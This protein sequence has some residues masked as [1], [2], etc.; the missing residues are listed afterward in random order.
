M[1]IILRSPVSNYITSVLN[2]QTGTIIPIVTAS[3]TILNSINIP[4]LYPYGS[5]LIK[6]E[7]FDKQT[8]QKV[9]YL[10]GNTEVYS[11]NGTSFFIQ[12]SISKPGNYI[13]NA[14]VPNDFT[15]EKGYLNVTVNYDYSRLFINRIFGSLRIL[16]NV[17]N[18]YVFDIV[19]TYGNHIN[20]SIQ[21][22]L[23]DLYVG[24]NFIPWINNLKGYESQ[25]SIVLSPD[26]NGI[27][28]FVF[29]VEKYGTYFIYITTNSNLGNTSI[30]NIFNYFFYINVLVSD[31]AS[32]CQEDRF[33]LEFSYGLIESIYLSKKI[34]VNNHLFKGL[35]FEK[36]FHFET[37]LTS[38]Q[39]LNYKINKPQ[40]LTSI[41]HR[42]DNSKG[43]VDPTIPWFNPKLR[44][45]SVYNKN[46]NKGNKVVTEFLLNNPKA[47]GLNSAS[48]TNMIIN[49]AREDGPD[50]FV[51]RGALTNTD[52][53]LKNIV[54]NRE[55]NIA[56]PLITNLLKINPVINKI[57]I[58][59]RLPQVET[60]TGSSSSETYYQK[61]KAILP[62]C[63]CE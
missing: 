36:R 27:Y 7:L 35:P 51:I 17:S 2:I 38:S 21:H 45:I 12:L 50:N 34:Q 58:L 25:P 23:P 13:L 22:P 52:V 26:S 3:I 4:V 43:T 46:I 41:P 57:D 55:L 47:R 56:D 20:N 49:Q 15:I 18:L 32:E 28:N 1:K 62:G 40:E 11:N 14:S 53:I 48:L 9:N 5:Y 42:V 33:N 10:R 30:Y 39:N 60:Q 54:T 19:D 24:I 6:L 16:P 31:N 44:P 29:N 63:N 37:G 61:Y 8:H 59:P